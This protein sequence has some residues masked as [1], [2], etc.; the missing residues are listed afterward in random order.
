MG[1]NE[2]TPI[3]DGNGNSVPLKDYIEAIIGERDKAA[4]AVHRRLEQRI[5]AMNKVRDEVAADRARF[6]TRDKYDTEHGILEDRTTSLEAWRGKA[7]GFGALL[8]LVA[9][10]MG[11]LIEAVV[12]RAVGT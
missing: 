10:A 12:S 11:A 2:H 5:D 4:E 1:L 6:L 7:L 8:A 3:H 9:A